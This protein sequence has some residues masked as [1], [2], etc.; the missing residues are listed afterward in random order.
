MGFCWPAGVL[1]DEDSS[2]KFLAL[3]TRSTLPEKMAGRVR[4]YAPVS[5]LRDTEPSSAGG[6]F[7]SQR[8]RPRWG[9]FVSRRSHPR[10]YSHHCQRPRSESRPVPTTSLTCRH[11]YRTTKEERA[12]KASRRLY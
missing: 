2:S 10:K 4:K 9:A 12:V 11:A 7:V 8:S 5:W 1:G 6:A 3:A